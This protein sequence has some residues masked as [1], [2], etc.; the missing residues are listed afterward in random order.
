AAEA[1]Y[2]Y[3]QTA[4]YLTQMAAVDSTARPLPAGAMTVEDALLRAHQLDPSN[5]AIAE[6]L[7]STYVAAEKWGRAAG[8]AEEILQIRPTEEGYV[9]LMRLYD[10]QKNYTAALQVLDRLEAMQADPVKIISRRVSYYERMGEMPK[11][12]ETAQTMAEKHPFE[13]R[14]VLAG[15]YLRNGYA[16]MSENIGRALVAEHPN[17]KEAHSLLLAAIAQQD[18]TRYVAQLGQTMA[19]DQLT[20]EDKRPFLVEY[21]QKAI[22]Q[23]AQRNQM[24]TI[25]LAAVLHP[26][27]GSSLASDLTSFAVELE[28][29]MQQYKPLLEA[30]VRDQPDNAQMRL[31]LAVALS[32]E[33]KSS[34][35]ES[36][37][38]QAIEQQPDEWV[39]YYNMAQW[40]GA[41]H[42][43]DEAIAI[44]QQGIDRWYA[45]EQERTGQTDASPADTIGASLSAAD[46]Q[47]AVASLHVLLAEFYMEANQSAKAFEQ[48]E[49][50]LQHDPTDIGTLN[51]YAYYMAER[52]TNLA[53]ARQL[54]EQLVSL[55]PDE[56]NVIDTYACVLLASR[57][58]KEAKAQI[59][60]ALKIAEESGEPLAPDYY[61]HAGDIYYYNGLRKQAVEHWRKALQQYEEAELDNP[62]Q[63]QL[64]QRRIKNKRP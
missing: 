3:A 30:A 64:I 42:R 9:G 53:R 1:L 40:L 61:I 7:L 11:A 59:D 12:L 52:K 36:L 56:Y 22:E 54:G 63:H 37:M 49:R 60:R 14:V 15:L 57:R 27:P 47:G 26:Q 5:T 50:A 32:Y 33:G 20:H 35:A 18:S 2:L 48:Y 4:E 41:N 31:A 23:P 17:S 25:M 8:V 34:E 19:S 39:N 43:S 51:N 58:Y 21:L 10:R 45:A 29:P 6:G 13:G 55:A 44:L 62:D 24:L 16:A 38:R 28:Y 46:D